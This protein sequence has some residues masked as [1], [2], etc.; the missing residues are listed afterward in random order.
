MIYRNNVKIKNATSANNKAPSGV[1]TSNSLA[2][3]P[4]GAYYRLD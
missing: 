4:N 1:M 3:I 2:D